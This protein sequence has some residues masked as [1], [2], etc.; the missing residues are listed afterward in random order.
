MLIEDDP[1]VPGLIHVT[2]PQTGL[3]RPAYDPS[4]TL[5][6]SLLQRVGPAEPPPA[7]SPEP[8]APVT[9]QDA[10]R[11]PPAG[12]PLPPTQPDPT[13]ERWGA[14]QAPRPAPTVRASGAPMPPPPAPP[15]TVLSKAKVEMGQPGYTYDKAAEEQRG[16]DLLER[17][18]EQ[19]RRAAVVDAVLNEQQIELEK[20]RADAEKRQAIEQEKAT[21][22]E[23]EL[24]DTVAR[25]I[26]PDRIKQN[27]P[28]MGSI[29][30]IVGQALGMLSKP[31]SGVY[32]WQEQV[33][34]DL[35]AR[36][37]RDIDSQKEQKQ[38]TINLLTKQLGSAE[39]AENHYRAQVN[40]LAADTIETRLKRLGMAD[41]YAD[42]IQ[43]L[44]DSA[45]AYNEAAKA[46][47][48]GKPGKAEYE[49]ERPKPEKGPG[50]VGAY[51]NETLAKL[52]GLGIDEKRYREGLDA[53]VDGSRT[54]RETGDN[55]KQLDSD[56]NALN[57]L[58]AANGGTLPTKGVVNIPQ[59]LVGTMAQ[60]GIES[61]MSAEQVN[62]IMQA[63]LEQRAKQIFGS[64]LSA[65]SWIQIKKE[66]GSSPEAYTRWLQRMRDIDNR[67]LRSAIE[68]Q[69]PGRGQEVFEILLGG[70][71]QNIGVPQPKA[72]PFE[73]RNAPEAQTERPPLSD[74]EERQK[75]NRER[76]KK[77]FTD[78]FSGE[79]PIIQGPTRSKF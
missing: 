54:V 51:T 69:F 4:G 58:A 77:N 43:G 30:G 44:R 34:R 16:E 57:S 2:D 36:V 66:I 41:L 71:S 24:K 7:Y 23:R 78:F 50:G 5:R 68:Q 37:Q 62:Q 22:Y 27:T 63:H 19:D 17:T 39:Q 31:G 48:Y 60:M 52:K 40:A 18:R 8:A 49:F 11:A 15:G 55:I 14:E 12:P 45:M 20:Q 3:R 38:S 73:T 29:L 46:A 13:A 9:V 59:S 75:T 21:R 61:G 1:E 32:R 6:A 67:K 65:E 26:N 47:S 28:V 76:V 33:Q 42:Q 64:Q 70:A 72:K 79:G 35:D 74:V 56:V 53:K 25:E 10:L